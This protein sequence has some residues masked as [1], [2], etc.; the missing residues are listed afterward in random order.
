MPRKICRLAVAPS[1]DDY[2]RSGCDRGH[3][4][5]AEDFAWDAGEMSD[6]FSMANMAPQLP[7]LNRDE[8]EHLEETVRAWAL[9]RGEL[10]I[11]TGPVLLARPKTIGPDHIAIPT[12]FWKV[13]V[14]PNQHQA[15]AFLMPQRAIKKGDLRP[16]QVSIEAVEDQA[17][18]TLPLPAGI[19][20]MEIPK[21]WPA[22]I[23][24]LREEKRRT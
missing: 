3:Q 13:I 17:R 18:L 6:S 24:G 15:V 4:A 9:A 16:W 10:V 20:A 2:E 5:P 23:A 22:S 21:L 11:Y 1:T 7:G 14:D 19:D 12:A 8:W